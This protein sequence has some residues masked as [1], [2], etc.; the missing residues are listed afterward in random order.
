MPSQ[1]GKIKHR[2]PA[3]QLTVFLADADPDRGGV[4]G[5]KRPLVVKSWSTV[6]DVKHVI[7]TRLHVP[8]NQQRLFF[9]GRELRNPHTLQDV[10]IYR[11]DETVLFQVCSCDRA[12]SQSSWLLEPYGT[13]K[14]PKVLHRLLLQCKRGMHL[15]L[16]P[17]LAL[18]GTGGTYFLPG[19][20]GQPLVCFK[21]QDE[22][23]FAVN[24]PRGQ[25]SFGGTAGGVTLRAGIRPGEA[26]IREVAAY[27]VDRHEFSGV[28]P[29][30]LVECQH[31]KFHYHDRR[32]VPKLGSLQQFVAN[33]GVAEDFA[34]SVFSVEQVHKIAVLDMRVLNCDRNA[35][36]LL[37]CEKTAS[38]TPRSPSSPPSAASVVSLSSPDPQPGGCRRWGR[39]LELV[40][41]DHGFCLP[42]VLDIG[43]C[44]WCWLDWP[45]AKEPLDPETFD[46][47]TQTMD[48]KRDAK[49]LHDKLALPRPALELSRLTG[50]LLQCGV[51]RGLTLHDVACLIVR[52]DLE[53]A[54]PSELEIAHRRAHQLAKL[55]VQNR[56]RPASSPTTAAAFPTPGAVAH[57]VDSD[58]VP[59]E[60]DLPELLAA[61]EAQPDAASPRTCDS[62]PG[63]WSEQ[64]DVAAAKADA[65]QGSEYDQTW[66]C[67]ACAEE[68]APP[69]PSAPARPPPSRPPP[70][71]AAKGKENQRVRAP[72]ALSLSINTDAPAGASPRSA[73]PLSSEEEEKDNP[74]SDFHQNAPHRERLPHGPCG[75]GNEGSGTSLTSARSFDDGD[76]FPGRPC[77]LI[78]VS[79]CP[80]VVDCTWATPTDGAASA[81]ATTTAAAFPE[82]DEHFWRFAEAL[83]N[84][85]VDRQLRRKASSVVRSPAAASTV[86]ETG[87]RATATTSSNPSPPVAAAATPS[88]PPAA[89]PP[90]LVPAGT[91]VR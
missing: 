21:P 20:K 43:W 26:C 77:S 74:A 71:E 60:L 9:R 40:P 6:K 28:P 39:D 11:S 81:G 36:N 48:P 82:Y 61:S 31:A 49:L 64:L 45:Q 76:L 19:P 88:E 15:G 33:V 10:G 91:M 53:S 7:S 63:F 54:V 58:A 75:D 85:T 12:A 25:T 80:S 47:V 13:V 44:D 4:L 34:S 57:P 50:M 73:R 78:R 41:V 62:P 86:H 2:R 55:A 1:S 84:G 37:V 65:Q 46:F 89:L 79:S 52:H 14:C 32:P 56:P 83:I 24:N 8:I 70:R 35:A 3:G 68:R 27:L 51:R 42:D 5:K 69:A 16:A 23:P 72:L 17:T 59:P 30:T 87:H 18:E 90:T 66:P 38:G 22:E 29:T 67:E